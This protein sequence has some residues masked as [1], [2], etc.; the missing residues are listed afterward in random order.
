MEILKRPLLTE[1]VAALN[2]KG[3]YGFVVDVK[4][5]KIQIKKAVEQMYGVNVDTV[6]TM[7]VAGKK[8]V[9][10]TKAGV[11]QGRKPKYKK[12]IVQLAE[13]E[14]IDFYSEG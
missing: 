9:R 4:A 7:V 13:G 12:A 8:K 3:V 14:I 1:K 11:T 2:E 10:S 5:N 6:R